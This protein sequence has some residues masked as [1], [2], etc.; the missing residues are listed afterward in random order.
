LDKGESS[1]ICLA[2]EMT[3]VILI[4]D[5]LRVRKE[6]KK[7]G[8]NYTGTLGV[9]FKTKQLGIITSLKAELSNLKANGFFI[10]PAIE[11]ELLLKCGEKNEI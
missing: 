10:L 3:D 7:L 2:L 9:L 8:L 5:D 4:L 11:D 1:A 6:A